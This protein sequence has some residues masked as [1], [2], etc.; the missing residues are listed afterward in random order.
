M[1]PITNLLKT[2]AKEIATETAAMVSDIYQVVKKSDGKK[3]E[4]MPPSPPKPDFD[5]E[6]AKIEFVGKSFE[7][8]YESMYRISSGKSGSPIGVLDDWDGRIYYMDT[9]PNLQ[10]FW[11]LLFENYESLSLPQLKE[12]AEKFIEFVF[13]TGIKRYNEAQLKV[14]ETTRYKYYADDELVIGTVMDVEYACWTFNNKVLEKG[15]LIPLKEER[16]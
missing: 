2:A 12:R 11:R 14:D 7:G 3:T 10:C 13:S 4:P 16:V 8:I 1:A 9:C 6:Q 15:T 5:M